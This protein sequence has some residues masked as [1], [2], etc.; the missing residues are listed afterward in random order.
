MSRADVILTKAYGGCRLHLWVRQSDLLQGG[1][2]IVIKLSV[3]RMGK[4]GFLIEETTVEAGR[5][6]KNTD[7]YICDVTVKYHL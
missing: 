6:T 2:R 7:G 1:D 3:E 5:Q 4:S